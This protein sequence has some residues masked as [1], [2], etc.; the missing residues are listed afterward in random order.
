VVLT[1]ATVEPDWL[2]LV[3]DD[4]TALVRGTFLEGCPVLG[5]SARPA[6]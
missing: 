2:E 1:S 5:V 4:V 3:R 6:A